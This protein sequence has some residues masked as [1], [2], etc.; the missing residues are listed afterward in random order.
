MQADYDGRGEYVEYKKYYMT[1]SLTNKSSG[2]IEQL[3]DFV[4]TQGRSKT[5]GV[6]WYLQGLALKISCSDI[7]LFNVVMNTCI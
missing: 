2:S 7:L 1:N 3:L 5:S 6:S 4:A